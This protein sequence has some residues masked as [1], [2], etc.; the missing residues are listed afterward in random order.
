MLFLWLVLWDDLIKL[1]IVQV[2]NHEAVQEYL[3]KNIEQYKKE[4]RK[5]ALPVLLY[6]FYSL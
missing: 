2:G 1:L 6:C 5:L 4:E 3:I